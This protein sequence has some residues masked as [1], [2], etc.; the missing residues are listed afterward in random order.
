MLNEKVN[1]IDKKLDDLFDFILESRFQKQQISQPTN[2]TEKISFPKEFQIVKK[3]STKALLD[4]DSD[5]DL[6]Q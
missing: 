2:H 5:P 1:T 3:E 4:P 6:L